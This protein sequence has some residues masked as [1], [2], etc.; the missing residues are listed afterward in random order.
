MIKTKVKNDNAFIYEWK[1]IF[2]HSYNCRE[3]VEE[4]E[5]EAITCNNGGA[6]EGLTPRKAAASMA[7][8]EPLKSQSKQ[9]IAQEGEHPSLAT[10]LGPRE[11]RRRRKGD[12]GGREE[13][14]EADI[15]RLAPGRNGGFQG[16]PSG[17]KRERPWRGNPL[18][19]DQKKSHDSLPS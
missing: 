1:Y 13:K 8:H 12:E 19:E 10:R 11:R 9:C 15:R 16:H 18:S 17:A 7:E 2:S 3:N 5:K 14:A 6:L 4:R